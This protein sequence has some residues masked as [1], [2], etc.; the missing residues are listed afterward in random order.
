MP[1]NNQRFDGAWGFK[2]AAL[3]IALLV[4]SSIAWAVP[5]QSGGNPIKVAVVIG[6]EAPELDRHAATELCGYLEKLYGIRTTPSDKASKKA[7]MVILVGNPE[8]N[9]A[10]A[11]AIGAEAWPKLTDQG[12]VLKRVSLDGKPTLIIGGGSPKATLWAVYEL[13]ERWG[14]RY[15]LH[16][17][18]LPD[19]AGEFQLP[20]EDVTLEPKLRI[21]QWRVVNDFA[22]GPESWGMA[23]YRPVLDQLAKLRFNRIYLSLYPWQPFLHWEHQGVARESAWLWFKF[24]YPITDDMPG[25]ELFGNRHEFWNPDLP[26]EAPYEEFVAAGEKLVHNLMAHAHARGME[27][28]MPVNVLEFP[29]EFKELPGDWE[30][31][32]QLESL[33]IV[34]G[35]KTSPDDPELIELAAT[36]LQA[37]VNTYPEVDYLSLGM[38]EH[39]QWAE[40]YEEAWQALDAKYGISQ[41][42]S[43]EDVIAAAGKRPG[44]PGGTARAIGEAKGDI[45]MLRFYD[46]LITEHRALA[47]SKRPDMKFVYN[48]VAEELFPILSKIVPPG[49]ETKN[50]LAYTPARVVQRRE[51]IAQLDTEEVPAILIFTLHDDNVGLLPALTTG[52][53]HELTKDLRQHGWAGFSTRYWLI[54]DHDPCVAYMARAVWDEEAT[55][56]SVYRDQVRAA[57]GAAAVED[58]LTMFRE[59][60]ETSILLEWK[61]L[62][63]GFAIP[64]MMMKH[65]Q[66]GPMPETFAKAREGYQRALAAAKQAREKTPEEKR[67]YIDYWIGRFE[68]GIGYFDVIEAV[69]AAATAE[70]SSKSDE[71]LRHAEEALAKA[72]TALEAYARVARDQ[73]DRGAIATLNEYVYRPLKEKVAELNDNH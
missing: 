46:R 23:D 18:V 22:S 50:F 45:V 7:E 40:R 68:F 44:V 15:L 51:A 14:V 42:T 56:E 36:V 6:K 1:E 73:S 58:M 24:K 19:N 25:R 54:G 64:G 9:P 53:L 3:G 11:K 49:S 61:A 33:T 13:V 20:T 72:R 39:R 10:I 21:R 65:W 35:S 27:C 57:C 32:K 63:L 70:K 8:T 55:P 59:L 34:P 4:S 2:S 52:S 43:L 38:P 29:P 71:T 17:D 12:L 47:E 66:P 37:T 48:A 31:V 5:A 62:G 41:I 30:S 69:R 16:G 26:L 60:E 67:A 28:M